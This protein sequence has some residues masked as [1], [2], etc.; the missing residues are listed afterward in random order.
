MTIMDFHAL[1]DGGSPEERPAP[2]AASGREL[3]ELLNP[4]SCEDFVNSWFGRTSL[5]V[6]GY[7]QKFESIFSWERLKH[8]LARGRNIPDK[9]YN[10][11]ASFSRGETSGKGKPMTSA[12][13]DQVS[14]LLNAGATICITNIHM[15]DATLARWAAA[16]RA[17]MNF[18]GTVGVNC[19]I[20]PDG[21]GLPTHYDKRVA[22][23]LQIAGK[24]RW[25]FS[26]E[27]AKAWPDHN[28]LYQDGRIEPQGIDGGKLPD[29]MEFREVELNPGDLLCLPAGAWHSA[30]G[31]GVSMA[32]N[33]YFSPRNF[34]DQLI[35]LLRA[36]ASEDGNWRGGPP[37]TV[38]AIRGD[39]PENV[40]RYM[41]ERLD[42]FC[43]LAR[44][45]LE[46]P[47]SMAEPWLSA[48]TQIPYTGWRPEP[49]RQIPGI[50]PA[51]PF[52]V[53][54]S[55]LRFV[56]QHDRIVVPCDSGL[57]NLP[58]ELA[59]MLNRLSTET[60]CFTIPELLSWPEVP[61]GYPREKTM[62]YLQQLYAN[63]ILEM[64]Q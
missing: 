39:I 37:A 34:V 12:T 20:S 22:T 60:G 18:A 53:G 56:K 30:R 61:E 46:N 10:I 51:Q 55:S 35:P 17:Q 29:E 3:E 49:K 14:D 36:F 24:K 7:A 58:L 63:G 33:V 5:N 6:E 9:R 48:L 11:T 28:G 21:A 23:T 45:T 42:E 38:G 26:T 15:A 32:L 25:R 27:A 13:H 47:G 16:L 62:A 4:V 52:Y 59:P 1:L 2:A 41:R 64:A 43:T 40:T 8:A 19:Y 31:V 44:E 57:L 54:K 50:T